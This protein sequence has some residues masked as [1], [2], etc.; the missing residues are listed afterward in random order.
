M[1]FEANRS[2]THQGACADPDQKLIREHALDQ[3][4]GGGGGGGGRGEGGDSRPVGQKKACFFLVLSL[5]Y[6]LQRVSNGL[7]AE[8]T[9]LS[10]GGGPAWGSKC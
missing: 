7:N 10:Q 4:G 1:L 6:R 3:G 5:F 8:K 2:E 9:I